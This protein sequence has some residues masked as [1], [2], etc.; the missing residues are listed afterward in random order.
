MGIKQNGGYGCVSKCRTGRK[1][2]AAFY[3]MNIKIETYNCL[4]ETK[5]FQVNGIDADWS[6][7]GDKYDR[8]PENAEDYCCADMRFTAKPATQEILNKYKINDNEYSKVCDVLA[9]KLSW[10]CCGWCS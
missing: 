8:E 3:F 5:V 6:D 9:D 1:F 7:F 2:S 4:C 10:G